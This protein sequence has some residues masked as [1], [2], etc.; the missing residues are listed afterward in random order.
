MAFWLAGWLP[1]CWQ[2]SWLAL[3]GYLV[4][5]ELAGSRPYWLGMDIALIGAPALCEIYQDGLKAQGCLAKSYSAEDMTLAGLKAAF[6]Q[7]KE[8]I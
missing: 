2:V 3:S 8:T 6:E 5:L 7:V 1:G 4:G